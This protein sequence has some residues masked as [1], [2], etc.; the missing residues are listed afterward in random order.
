M[1]NFHV[2]MTHCS[3]VTLLAPLT[4]EGTKNSASPVYGQRA[5]VGF[6]IKSNQTSQVPSNIRP[7][8]ASET[9]GEQRGVYRAC[10]WA[11]RPAKSLIG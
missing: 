2:N 7:E 4:Q 1:M 3:S 6:H 5:W 10:K 11:S 9:T 8:V